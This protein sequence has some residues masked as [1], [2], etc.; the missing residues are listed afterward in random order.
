MKARTGEAAASL[1]PDLSAETFDSDEALARLEFQ[2]PDLERFPCL[3]LAYRALAR[4]GTVPAALSAANE[5]AVEAF[6]GGRIRFGEIAEVVQTAMDGTLAEPLSL[7]AVRAAD[8]RARELA[9]EAVEAR[10]AALSKP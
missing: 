8:A 7:G 5:I 3:G 1:G 2:R 10:L 4:G 6:V 9:R